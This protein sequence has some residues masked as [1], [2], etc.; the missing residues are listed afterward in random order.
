MELVCSCF[1]D[2]R[3]G[4][5]GW[6]SWHNSS[7]LAPLHPKISKP[8][9]I[10][11]SS[12]HL[13]IFSK[14]CAVLNKQQH[15]SWHKYDYP[16]SRFAA[17]WVIYM[18]LGIPTIHCVDLLYDPK[19]ILYLQ[20]SFDSGWH[21]PF[22]LSRNSWVISSVLFYNGM[23]SSIISWGCWRDDSHFRGNILGSV[24]KLYSDSKIFR[25]S[26]PP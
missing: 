5:A 8:F 10:V 21:S 23:L 20:I 7:K 4:S 18:H 1:L 11:N 19:F 6:N 25:L 14:L 26:F 2:Y 22:A 17:S 13:L 24:I 16:L 9:P 12:W 15:E 3:F